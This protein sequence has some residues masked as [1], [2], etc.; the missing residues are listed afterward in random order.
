MNI[1]SK[2]NLD[3]VFNFSN[4]NEKITFLKESIND[5]NL[6]NLYLVKIDFSLNN[7]SF[8]FNDLSNKEE[9]LSILERFLMGDLKEEEINNLKK[10]DQIDALTNKFGQIEIKDLEEMK[11]GFSD[12]IK[13]FKNEVIKNSFLE[14]SNFSSYN[15]IYLSK[16]KSKEI[17]KEKLIMTDSILDIF[18]F[19]NNSG[20]TILHIDLSSLESLDSFS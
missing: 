5:F 6:E 14:E 3:T 20:K 2:I 12:Y 19:F 15:L 10:Y 1:D 13:L 8:D 11:E 18:S 17:F 9:M 7:D 4:I 16:G